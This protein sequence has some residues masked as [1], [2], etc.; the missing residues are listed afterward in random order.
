[1]HS[2]N[3]SILRHRKRLMFPVILLTVCVLLSGCRTSPV[4]SGALR[5]DDI[6]YLRLPI[7]DGQQESITLGSDHIAARSFVPV[8]S[9]TDI[10]TAIV[11]DPLWTDLED[12]RHSWCDHAPSSV[13]RTPDDGAFEVTFQCHILSGFSNP[14]YYVRPS[15][16]PVQL[17]ALIEL[18]P[19]TTRQ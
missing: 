12:L 10:N 17:H 6:L 13:S 3:H 19:P 1:M 14:S 2:N 9:A 15:E 16:L 11:S 4:G 7:Q 18:M 5:G 8:T